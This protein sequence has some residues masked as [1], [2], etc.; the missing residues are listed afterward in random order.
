M[1]EHKKI[2]LLLTDFLLNHK[3]YEY[4]L[5]FTEIYDDRSDIFQKVFSYFHES[6]NR[7]FEFMNTKSVINNHYNADS[8]RELINIIDELKVIKKGLQ[9]SDFNFKIEDT[10]LKQIKY[11]RNFLNQFGGSPIPDDY[12]KFKV[13]KYEPR[14][15]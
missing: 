12:K 4:D 8:S 15:V 9:N 6:F 13:I 7:L 10:Y 3:D 2:K 1:Q 5:V 11:V 14:C